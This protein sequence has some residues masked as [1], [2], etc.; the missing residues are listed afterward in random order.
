MAI[1]HPANV[2]SALLRVTPDRVLTL[3]VHLD[4][5]AYVL[6]ATPAEIPDSPMNQLL[7]GPSLDLDARLRAAKLRFAR[8][9]DLEADGHRLPIERIDFPTAADVAAWV[10]TAGKQRLPVMLNVVVSSHVPPSGAELTVKFPEVMDTVVLTCEMPNTEPASQP[11]EP[12][13][14]SDPIALGAVSPP[15]RDRLGV[16][17]AR[18]TIPASTPDSST[19][20]GATKIAPAIPITHPRPLAQGRGNSNSKPRITPPLREGLG[21]DDAWNPTSSNSIEFFTSTLPHAGTPTLPHAT[22]PALPHTQSSLAHFP[23]YV[24]MGFRH[25]V[26]EGLDHILF[27]LGLFLL[28]TRWKDLLKQISAFTLA[29]SITLALSLYGVFRLPP[30]IVEPIIALSI[31]FVAVEN[32]LTKELKAW[33]IYVVFLFGLVH[34]LGF[35]GALQDAGLQRADFLTALVGFNSGVELGQLAVVASAFALVGWF[36]S[37]ARYRTAIVVPASVAIACVALFWTVQRIF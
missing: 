17:A 20:S 6:D 19:G 22:T 13:S 8:Q 27:V 34:G 26:P 28:S 18:R 14:V 32:V 31:V 29:H 21:V 30:A 3:R 16:G 37:S 15:L 4:L 7:D 5:L 1:A 25:I 2:P 9:I 10:R 24:R 11:V 12:G 23:A 36:R 35:A 33:R